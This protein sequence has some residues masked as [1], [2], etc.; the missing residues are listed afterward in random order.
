MAVKIFNSTETEY[1]GTVDAD[2][3]F[4]NNLGNFIDSGD[5]DDVIYGGA[6]DDI[7]LGGEGND[8]ILGGTGNDVIDLGEGNN[9]AVAAQVTIS[10]LQVVA[11][12]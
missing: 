5:G 8:A 11:M 12:M 6:G 4:G 10:F 9:A 1:T 3:I 2:L 7:L